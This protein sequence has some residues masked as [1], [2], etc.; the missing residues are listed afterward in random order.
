[1]LI[2]WDNPQSLPAPR[3]KVVADRLDRNRLL[4]LKDK[5]RKHKSGKAHSTN[6]ERS[7]ESKAK[8]AKTRKATAKRERGYFAYVYR[9]RAYWAGEIPEHPVK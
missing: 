4:V 5:R 3:R 7:L 2:D 6:R 9:V 8:V 1:M